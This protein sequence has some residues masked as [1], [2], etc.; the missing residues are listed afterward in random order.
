MPNSSP[1]DRE[2]LNT[3]LDA[4]GGDPEFLAELLDE[5][6]KDAPVQFQN[7]E[8]ALAT[9]NTE[10]FRRAA[11]SMKSNSANFGALA[12]SS[13]CK[14][15]EEMGKNGQLGEAAPLLAQAKAEYPTVKSALEAALKEI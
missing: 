4:V 1:I 7:M 10:A 11:H 15:L 8:N 6:F 9:H 5:F 12:L 2:T 14:D 13:M 3:L